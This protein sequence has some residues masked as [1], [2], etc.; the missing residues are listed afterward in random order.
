MARRGVGLAL[1]AGLLLGGCADDGSVP[2][3]V[4]DSLLTTIGGSGGDAAPAAAGDVP[5]EEGSGGLLGGNLFSGQGMP[6]YVGGRRLNCPDGAA[7]C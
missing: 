1:V 7:E 6:I 4:G 2:I 3:Y 5:R